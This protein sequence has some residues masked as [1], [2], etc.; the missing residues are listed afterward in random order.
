MSRKCYTRCYP[1]RIGKSSFYVIELDVLI[2]Y[3]AQDDIIIREFIFSLS[4][5]KNKPSFC[6]GSCDEIQ[7]TTKL[8]N[9]LHWKILETPVNLFMKF[10][11]NTLES[12]L[13]H[14]WNYFET[15]FELL[16]DTLKLP[17][18]TLKGL[19]GN[20]S[21]FLKTPLKLPWNTHSTSLK[22]SWNLLKTPFKHTSIFLEAS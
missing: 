8:Q 18:I 22:H 12:S 2:Q 13:K 17:W 3:F 5:K 10:S 11:W 21:I 4:L 7:S 19:S 20:P 16:L 6:S 1:R 15:P 9:K 14:F